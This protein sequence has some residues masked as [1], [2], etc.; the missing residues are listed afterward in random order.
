MKEKRILVTGA[1][2]PVALEWCRLLHA[3]GHQVFLA[4]SFDVCLA[5]YSNCIQNFIEVAQPRFHFQDFLSDIKN[6][7]EEKTIDLVIP[8]CEEAF[9]LARVA[10]EW[11]DFSHLLFSEKK[12]KM[13]KLHSKFEFISWAKK[14]GLTVPETQK[15]PMDSVTGDLDIDADQWIVKPEYSRFA[16]RVVLNSK[17]LQKWFKKRPW[18]R[19]SWIVQQRVYG[20]EFSTYSICHKGRV[21]LHV[22]YESLFRAGQGAGIA[23]RKKH[24]SQVSRWVTTFVEKTSYTGQIAFDFI[25]SDEGVLYPIE[26]NPRATS[27]LHFFSESPV[28]VERALFDAGSSSDIEFSLETEQTIILRPVMW[29]YG[30]LSAIR[31]RRI[32]EWWSVLNSSRDIMEHSRDPMSVPRQTAV[33]LK[34]CWL[35]ILQRMPLIDLLT[36]DIEWN[37]GEK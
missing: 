13:L 36:Y 17:G 27:G 26:C 22:T 35:G 30:L 8:T 19:Q 15:I 33:F 14:L 7:V 34:I 6:I 32:G 29:S 23:M 21:N 31:E 10:D 28:H 12:E 18:S 2:A 16:N 3:Q 24:I 25:M 5:K 20:K 4:D 9:F 1:R 37:G 11:P